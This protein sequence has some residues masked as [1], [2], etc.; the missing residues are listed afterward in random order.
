MHFIS[1]GVCFQFECQ[2][3]NLVLCS[4]VKSNF[5][6]IFE[7]KIA[8]VAV[9]GKNVSWCGNCMNSYCKNN[10]LFVKAFD[11]Q[12]DVLKFHYIVHTALDVIEDKGIISF[13]RTKNEFCW[14][15]DKHKSSTA[16]S[17]DS[18]PASGS[19]PKGVEMYMG[20]LC[21]TEDYRVYDLLQHPFSFCRFGYVTNTRNKL[22]VVVDDS[23]IKEHDIKSV[24]SFYFIHM[25]SSSN[26]FTHFLQT[27]FAIHFTLLMKR[28][29]A[30]NLNESLWNL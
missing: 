16:H 10:P 23:E 1:F 4:W 8:C 5:V 30:R 28:L 25:S 22:I 29:Q 6:L 19:K 27:P 3:E 12:A 11:L 14:F 26:L 20:F 15:I 21:P 9:V 24:S 2:G 13:S 18:S 17:L 7:M